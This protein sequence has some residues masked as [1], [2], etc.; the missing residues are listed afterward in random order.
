MPVSY[1]Y[2]PAQSS[3]LGRSDSRPCRHR[4]PCAPNFLFAA[5]QG[6]SKCRLR[7]RS[8]VCGLS[9][10]PELRPGDVHRQHAA[11]KCQGVSSQ[12]RRLAQPHVRASAGA[13]VVRSGQWTS[14]AQCWTGA[15]RQI[16]VRW[17][18]VD[19]RMNACLTAAKPAK[20]I[21]CVVLAG[22]SFYSHFLLHTG[23]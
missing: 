3:F 5:R 18:R 17:G 11:R 6:N 15:D 2:Q 7:R 20:P 21:I 14:S 4:S 8:A 16:L 23:P 12:A 1:S 13:C 22:Q 9:R 19:L 10:W